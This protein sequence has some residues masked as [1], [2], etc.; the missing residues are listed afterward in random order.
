MGRGGRGRVGQAAVVDRAAPHLAPPRRRGR[1]AARRAR[2]DRATTA[3]CSCG[4]GGSSLAP[5]VICATAGVPIVV[6]DSSDPDVVRGAADRPRAHRRRRVEQV[7]LHR[8]DRQPAAGVRAGLHATPASTPTTPDRRRHRPRQ[9]ARRRRPRGRLP[10]RQRRPRRRR[11]L[12]RAHRVRPGAQRPGRR[13]HRGPARRRRGGRRPARRRRRRQPGAAPGRR[14]GAAPSRCATSSCSSTTAP[15][16]SASATGP[17][18]SSPSP[19]ARTAPASCPVVAI[20]TEPAHLYDDGTVVRLVASDD[21]PTPADAASSA[22]AASLVTV[23]GPLGA[24]LLLW[25]A[26]T[27]VAGRLLGINPFDQP[28]VESAKSAARELLDAGIG[29]GER[30]GVHRRRGR[31][32]RLGGDWLGDATTV[33]A[34]VDALLGAARRRAGLRRRDGLPRPRGRRRPRARRAATCSTAPAG[35]ATFGW[36]PR[37]L[38][39]TGQYHKG[40]P[41]TGVYV[42]VTRHA[43]E[44]LAVPGRDSPSAS[45][46]PPRPA[47]TPRCSP[48]TAG[49]VLRLHLTDA[50]RRPARRSGRRSGRGRGREPGP[51]RRRA[52]NPLRDPRD[53]RL[54]RIAGPCSLVLFGVTGDLARKK[55]MPAI[56]DL[57]NRGLLP[58]GFSLIG[59]AR[60]DWA[61]Q[62]FGKIVY[63]SVRERARTPFRE[64]VWRSL[65][66]GIRFVPGTFDDDASFDLLAQ[67]VAELDEQRGT[68]GN[69]AFYLSIPPSSFA[70]VCQQ[71]ERSG[72]VDPHAG[73]VAPGRHREAVRPRP[74]VGPRAQRHRRERLP[75]RLGVPHR[76][77]PGQGDGPEPAGAALRQPAVRAG[78]ERQL[79]RPRADHD[80]RGHRHRRPGRLLR[81]H[82]RRPR[83]HP[84]PPAAAARAHRDGGAGLL[85]R[86]RAC[87][88]RRRRCSRRCGC[89]PT[90]P[91]GTARG[92][93][94][95]GWQGG[96]GVGGYLDEDGVAAGLAHRDVRRGAPRRR[97]PPLGRGA[98]L[99]AHRQAAAASGSPRSPWCS[100]RRRTCR[101][102]TPRPRSSGRTPSSSGCSP[103][104][105]SRCG[106]ARRCP[107][108]QME[109]RDV[110]MDFG[111]GR[112]FTESS[113]GGLRAAHPRRAARRAAAVPAARGGRAVLADP[114]PD[115]GVL[116]Q[117]GPKPEQYTSGGWGP[118]RRRR[119]DASRRTRVEAAVIV[120][121]PEHRRTADDRQ[122]AGPAARRHRRRW[123]C[124]GVLTLLVVVDETDAD[125]AI[126]AANAASRQ[127][128][129]RII[130]VV[131]G[132]KRGATRLDAQIRVG[133]DAGASRGRRAAPLRPARRARPG[134]GHPAAARRL[135]DRRLVAH[136][137]PGQAVGRPDRRDGA[138]PGHRR[139]R[140]PARRRARR[141]DAWPRATSTA[142][143]TWPGRGSRCG[144]ACSPPPSTSRPTSRSPSAT[145]VAAAGLALRRPARRLAGRAAALPGLDR[146]GP[147]PQRHHL[148]APRARQRHGRPGAPA[149]RQ[150]R[151]AVPAR[152]AG[153]HR[154]RSRTAATPSASPT[155]CAASTPTRSTRTPWSTG[156]RQVHR[157]APDGHA[158]RSAPARRRRSPRR[159]A[160]RPGCAARRG[161]ARA[162]QMVEAQ[163]MPAQGRR[164][165]RGEEGRGHA[166][167]RGRRS[168]AH[169]RHR[170]HR[171]GPPRTAGPGRRRRRPAAS[172]PSSTRSRRA[173]WPTCR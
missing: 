145:V 137:R 7:R 30:P 34:A 39:S 163:P 164:P 49:P 133:G 116:G 165:G 101:S 73:V 72:L 78:L 18:S 142:T 102:R 153:A 59:F 103:T 131:A 126:D 117:E 96:E 77:L 11:P 113:P 42:Q 35:P 54:P 107:G 143:P 104:R 154:W 114:R 4:M 115:R 121:L 9:P 36:G 158:R 50:R 82:R 85:R 14:D 6:L 31:G 81:R 87:A 60:R 147:Q 40:G 28:D 71:L 52:R 90:S 68:G 106:S 92:Q 58:P 57:A 26:A 120:D 69:H 16:T 15:R 86:R 122:E 148:G 83:R 94:A 97:H 105:A 45:S 62:D 33:D 135:P 112:A 24:Q 23:A 99:P 93:Y 108:A 167:R 10:G 3:S 130:V 152:P 65:A 160:P 118:D 61:D 169:D 132:N 55:L 8:R 19:P 80:G 127:H 51:R 161:P 156:L 5:E 37:F 56:Y 20:G 48:T 95:A 84:E 43:A 140:S 76:P 63:E 41:P 70:T 124:P 162:A 141:C 75:R 146:P 151:D 22:A 138:A 100:R 38:H 27:A 44:D 134:R 111:Y 125:A 109:V 119:D 21:D 159:S 25:E 144:A 1:R 12:L 64:E 157:V 129:C 13:R 139:R 170:R 88:P 173:A 32:A 29:A 91:A 110:T 89:P 166:A 136:A 2:R 171:R 66:E 79:R 47:A 46:S 128:P 53:K 149:R 98:V 172:W 123:P 67:A 74:E 168:A 17:S 150:H 155:S